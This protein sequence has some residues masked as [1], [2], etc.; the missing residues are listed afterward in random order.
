MAEAGM[1]LLSHTGTEMTVKNF[2][3]NFGDPKKLKEISLAKST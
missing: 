2:D 1:V 3:P